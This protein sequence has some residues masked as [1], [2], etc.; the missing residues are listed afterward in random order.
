VAVPT[1]TIHYNAVKQTFHIPGVLQQFV[2]HISQCGEC[3]MHECLQ[4]TPKR[5][6]KAF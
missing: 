6:E 2:T 3:A 1:F 4:A 5:P